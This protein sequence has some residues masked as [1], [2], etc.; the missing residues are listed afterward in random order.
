MKTV[1]SFLILSI[2]LVSTSIFAQPPGGGQRGGQ[3]GPPPIPNNKQI[4]KMVSDLV[5]EIALSNEQETKVL[6]LYKEHF[7]QVKEKTS[8]NSRPNRD[9]METLK[10]TFE[11]SVKAELTKEQVSKYE[12]YLKNQRPQRK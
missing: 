8:G 12:T 5:D 7:A 6:S 2:L 9:E 4:K 3:Q 11:K 10:T 1:K